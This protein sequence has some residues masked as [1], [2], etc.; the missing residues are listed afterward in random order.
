MKNTVEPDVINPRCPVTPDFLKGG[1]PLERQDIQEQRGK[2]MG[3][4][5]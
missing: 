1:E 3:D 4:V 5:H 2:I